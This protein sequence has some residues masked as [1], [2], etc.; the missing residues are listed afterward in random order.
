MC[1]TVKQACIYGWPEQSKPKGEI[2]QYAPEASHLTIQDGI[3]LYG[4]RLVIPT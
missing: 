1:E 2:K 3:L 4:D